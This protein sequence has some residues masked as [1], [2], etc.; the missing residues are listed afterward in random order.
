MKQITYSGLGNYRVLFINFNYGLYENPTNITNIDEYFLNHTGDHISFSNY[1][2]GLSDNAQLLVNQGSFLFYVRMQI[3][4]TKQFNQ[5]QFSGIV[6][7][8]LQFC[9]NIGTG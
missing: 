6:F 2:F 5:N 1:F 4:H 9:W 8:L 3:Y 7:D